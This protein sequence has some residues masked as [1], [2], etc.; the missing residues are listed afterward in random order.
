[1]KLRAH[2]FSN[3]AAWLMISAFGPA[4]LGVLAY[5]IIYSLKHWFW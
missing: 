3:E 5:L 1:M 2:S 4:I